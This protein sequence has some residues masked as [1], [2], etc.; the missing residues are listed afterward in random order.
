MIFDA[1]YICC[2]IIYLT[3]VKYV[4]III[5]IRLTGGSISMII[6]LAESTNNHG[7]TL[8]AE[9]V[10]QTNIF[11]FHSRSRC[12]LVRLTF[13]ISGTKTDPL[14]I[15]ESADWFNW[16]SSNPD[17]KDVVESLGYMADDY[18]YQPNYDENCY[19]K[20]RNLLDY[21]N[22]VLDDEDTSI[23]DEFEDEDYIYYDSSKQDE[24]IQ[25]NVEEEHYVYRGKKTLG[26]I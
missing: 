19:K 16:I 23:D 22:K 13:N 3:A 12:I 8:E 11:N 10:E 20:V 14:Y 17:I 6:G 5:I 2:G 18:Y 4:V 21:I 7:I 26:P 1:A 9:M 15:V 25:E 24:E